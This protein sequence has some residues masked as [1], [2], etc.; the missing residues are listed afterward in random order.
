MLTFIE[1]TQTNA[2]LETESTSVVDW[3]WG[4]WK[5]P[6]KRTV[7]LVVKLRNI[8]KTTGLCTLNR[9]IL[10]H[11]NYIS[12]QP[13]QRRGTKDKG[14]MDAELGCRGEMRGLPQRSEVSR[15]TR[16]RKEQAGDTC[17]NLIKRRTHMCSQYSV[18][19]PEISQKTRPLKTRSCL[20]WIQA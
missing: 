11:T 4:W 3:G 7:V 10:C 19:H 12:K 5:C 2:N 18:V 9:W 1:N 16:E 15:G 6:L 13:I 20:T 14:N 8:L 17:L